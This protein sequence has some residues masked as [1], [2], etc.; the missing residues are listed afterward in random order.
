MGFVLGK[1]SLY[2]REASRCPERYGHMDRRICLPKMMEH[3]GI[4]MQKT[5]NLFLPKQKLYFGTV[6]KQYRI[7]RVDER[8]IVK[9]QV[10]LGFVIVFSLKKT[11]TG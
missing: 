1:V 11:M 6:R 7:F 2:R 8:L 5:M 4:E 9:A 3:V 10:N